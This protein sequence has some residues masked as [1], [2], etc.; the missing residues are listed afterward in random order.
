M[1]ARLVCSDQS[2]VRC[3]RNRR[4]LSK[5][6]PIS[7]TN[8][9]SLLDRRGPMRLVNGVTWDWIDVHRVLMVG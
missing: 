4:G 3:Y 2:S 6:L 9:R 5:P 8:E 7:A 1:L